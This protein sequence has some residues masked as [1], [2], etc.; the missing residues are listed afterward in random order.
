LALPYGLQDSL[1]PITHALLFV[2]GSLAVLELPLTVAVFGLPVVAVALL[3]SPLTVD[4]LLWL[5]EC[6]PVRFSLEK[7]WV[8]P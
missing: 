6:V 7:P 5:P 2:P 3:V 4:G 8:P 1:S